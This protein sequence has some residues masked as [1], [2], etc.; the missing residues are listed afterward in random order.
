MTSYVFCFTSQISNSIVVN[1]FSCWFRLK[2]KLRK[3]C[4]IVVSSKYVLFK[5]LFGFGGRLQAC[6][7][8]LDFKYVLDLHSFV[9]HKLPED[10]NLVPKPI[11]VGT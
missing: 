11:A 2:G 7:P 1:D 4:Y 6:G 5:F 9:V 10:D 3:P 8:L